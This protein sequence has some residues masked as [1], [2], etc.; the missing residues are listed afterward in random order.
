MS[1][2]NWLHLFIGLACAVALWLASQQDTDNEG[3]YR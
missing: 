2:A 1:G 3:W